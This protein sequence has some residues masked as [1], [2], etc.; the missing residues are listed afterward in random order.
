MTLEKTRLTS[1]EAKERLSKYGLNEIKDISKNTPF[2]I[3]LRQIKS[4]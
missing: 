3:L 1:V 2:K 4:K